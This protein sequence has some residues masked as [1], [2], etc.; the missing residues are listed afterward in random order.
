[1]N[2][3]SLEEGSIESKNVGANEIWAEQER[4][5]GSGKEKSINRHKMTGRWRHF[6]IR[7]ENREW[8]SFKRF[9]KVKFEVRRVRRFTKCIWNLPDDD[10]IGSSPVEKIA[11]A[12]GCKPM[13]VNNCTVRGLGSDWVTN[14]RTPADLR[15]WISGHLDPASLVTLTLIWK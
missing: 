4:V 8:A 3:K 2:L 9:Q 12:L 15:G 1:M 6:R 14:P 10:V 5:E 7:P 13:W 11:N